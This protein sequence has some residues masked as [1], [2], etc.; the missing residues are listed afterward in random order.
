M[1][2]LIVDARRAMRT[3]VIRML[4]QA[5]YIHALVEASNG[6]EALKVIEA[7][8]PDLVLSGWSLPDLTGIELLEDLNRRYI[9]INFGFVTSDST[10]EMR[11]R[12]QD[13]G[14]LFLIAKP[15]TADTFRQALAP[16]LGAG[17]GT[18]ATSAVAESAARIRANDEISE[19]EVFLTSSEQ[20]GFLM[21]FTSADGRRSY[22]CFRRSEARDL[23]SW[24]ARWT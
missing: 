7:D 2:I 1:K 17:Y 16:V 23:L 14:A 8:V 9:K 11:R 20:G 4:H 24:I 10:P 5:G 22:L 18:Q 15:F 6:M 13:A 21:E 19:G 3:I 12:A